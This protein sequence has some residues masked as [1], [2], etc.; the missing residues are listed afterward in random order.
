[1]LIIFILVSLGVWFLV[2]LIWPGFFDLFK[3][4]CLTDNIPLA[5]LRNWPF[6][7][8]GLVLALLI[9]RKLKKVRAKEVLF[10]QDIYKSV[11]AGFLEEIGFRCL[12]IFT[13]MIPLA[14]INFLLFGV[15]SWVY[16]NI[17]FFIANVLTLG[18]MSGTIYGIPVLLMAGAIS[19]N[20]AFRDGHKYQG[21]FGYINSWFAGMY[22]LNVMFTQGLLIAIL[23]HMIYDLI[24]A[25]VEYGVR[26]LNNE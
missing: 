26:S 12:F 13:A 4:W 8:Y 18:Q 9:T 22:L 20:A 14:I 5:V 17:I 24:I 1:M 16:S 25:F 10:A 23:V 6:L 7:V 2:N 15:A 19:A 11:M 3:Y 21:I